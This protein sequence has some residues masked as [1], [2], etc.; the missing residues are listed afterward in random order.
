MVET[1][2]ESAWKHVSDD[3]FLLLALKNARWIKQFQCGENGKLRRNYKNGKSNIDGFLEDYAN[4]IAAFIRLYEATF[5]E[6]WIEIAAEWTVF[7]KVHFQDEKSKM[8]YFTS[9]ETE[10]IARKMELND[11][12]MPA[13]NSVMAS[14]LFLLGKY[15]DEPIYTQEAEQMISNIYDGMENYGSGYSNWSNVLL[16][17]VQP[18]GEI[19]VSGPDEAQ[20]RSKI[21]SIYLPNVILHGGQKRSLPILKDK[22]FN[23]DNEISICHNQTCFA[24]VSDALSAL[25]IVK[26]LNN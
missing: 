6:S 21:A 26:N 16:N 25:E 14:N 12:V 3:Y 20:I 18:F 11:N 2:I 15:L 13:S 23:A 17:F 24:P 8:F 7:T 19:C 22:L 10:L 5:D 1:A 4:S 9:N